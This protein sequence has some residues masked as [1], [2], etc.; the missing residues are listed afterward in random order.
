MKTIVVTAILI[1]ASPFAQAQEALPVFSEGAEGLGLGFGVGEPTGLAIAFRP[2]ADHTIAAMVGWT[3]TKGQLHVHTDYLLTVAKIDPPESVISL[4]VYGGVGPTLDLDREYK[5]NGLGLRL[6]LGVSI[7]FDKPIDI[8]VE[9]A[10]TMGVL[11]DLNMSAGGTVGVRGWFAPKQ[12]S[13]LDQLRN[14]DAL[15][16][17]TKIPAE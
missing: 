6:P 8:F 7:A 17:R 15:N 2:N 11:P 1:F 9:L 4:N 13:S 12:G 3:L 5:R 16:T 14:H 10:P